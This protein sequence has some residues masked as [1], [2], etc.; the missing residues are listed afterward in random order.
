MPITRRYRPGRSS[1]TAIC[2]RHVLIK[3]IKAEAYVR[4]ACRGG[5]QLL[6]FTLEWKEF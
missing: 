1:V 4:H 5:Q 6:T 3:A 2:S